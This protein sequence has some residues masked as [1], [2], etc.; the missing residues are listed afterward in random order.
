[1][2]VDGAGGS[3]AFLFVW[4]VSQSQI[5]SFLFSRAILAL[6]NAFFTGICLMLLHVPYWYRWRCSAVWFR[7]SFLCW[8]RISAARC[9][10]CSHGVAGGL[11]QAVAVLVFICVY[12]QIENLIFA[13][14]ISQRTMDV[15]DAVAFLAVLAFTSLFGALARSSHCR[16]SRPCRRSSAPIQSGTSWSIPR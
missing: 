9:Q 1:M 14:K 11:W 2:P 15:N 5:S 3:A 8:V 13:P 12:Q 10:C 6:L 7:S 16:W 4:T